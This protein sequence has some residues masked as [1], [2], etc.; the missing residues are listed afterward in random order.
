MKRTQT[1]KTQRHPIRT[2]LTSAQS[3]GQGTAQA[4]AKPIT[5]SK[6]RVLSFRVTE[7]QHAEI[8]ARC[9]NNH[10]EQLLTPSEFAR[11]TV[12]HQRMIQPSELPLERFRLAIAAQLATAVTEMVQYLDAATPISYEKDIHGFQHVCDELAKIQ[13]SIL[14][15]LNNTNKLQR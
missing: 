3:T 9:K 11:Y 5:P 2:A 10:G 1:E 13:A 6:N 12:L 8:V 7:K 15:L 4:I 14:L